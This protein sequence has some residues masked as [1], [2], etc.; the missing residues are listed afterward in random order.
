MTEETQAEVVEVTEAAPVE[1]SEES[2]SPVEDSPKPTDEKP[3]DEEKPQEKLLTQKEVDEAIQRRLSRESR[4][5]ERQIRAEFENKMLRE[6]LSAQTKPETPT[7][8]SGEPKPEQFKDYESYIDALTDYKVEKKLAGVQE[9]SAQ[10]RQAE[11]QQQAEQRIRDNLSKA[12]EKYEDF[13]EVVTNPSLPITAAMR[14]SIGESDIGGELA[15]YLGTHANEAA[16]IAKL[17]PVQQVKAIDRLEQKLK[18]PAKVSE[19]P[20]PAQVVG[21]GKA[22][23]AIDLNSASLDDYMKMRAKQGARWANH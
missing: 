2:A 14:D 18:A 4:K 12:A 19:A 15:Y 21:K 16:E 6:Q 5:L 20:A 22:T 7:Q 13:E 9:R 3:K 1:K 11:A 10:Q 17:S 23:Q 8:P